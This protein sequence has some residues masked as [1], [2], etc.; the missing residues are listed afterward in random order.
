[1]GELTILEFSGTPQVLCPARSDTPLSLKGFVLLVGLARG[2][3]AY[4]AADGRLAA[5]RPREVLVLESATATE[6]R[7]QAG[8]RL[9]GVTSPIHLISPR[10]VTRDRLRAGASRS[11]GRGMA[12]LLYDLLISLAVH[13]RAAPGAGALADAVGGLL[14][15]M[16][17]DCLSPQGAEHGEA[18]RAR[19]DQIAGHVR[20]HFADP[21]L[22]A[23]D[24]A[25]ATGVSRRY[26]HKLYAQH[27][28][29]FRQELIALR[30]E[31]CMKAFMDEHQA[32]KTI[33]E[34][35]FAAGYTDISQ[36][37]RHFRKLKG[38]TPS[39]ARREAFNE[40]LAERKNP[41]G[42]AA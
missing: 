12:P 30:I 2:E 37:N 4:R 5:L 6:L 28:R 3:C 38:T 32:E 41:R 14:S 24:V 35:A 11:H 17:E 42:K 40:I 33:A 9:V 22:A 23:A 25:D 8:A 10:F 34:I 13:E 18:G 27:G 7:G 31:A 36:F 15:A 21:D 19:L 1:M 20:R 16:L 29:S 26:L 39:A